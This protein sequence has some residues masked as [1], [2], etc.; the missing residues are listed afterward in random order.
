MSREGSVTSYRKIQVL[1]GFL[2]EAAFELSLE[3]W[4]ENLVGFREG[5]GDMCAKRR[6]LPKLR[7]GGNRKGQVC[8][9]RTCGQGRESTLQSQVGLV[10]KDPEV[11]LRWN[12]F[13]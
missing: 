13:R 3:G 8:G 1:E 9:W 10:L 11:S 5:S 7:K 2:E 6:E 4:G 12:L